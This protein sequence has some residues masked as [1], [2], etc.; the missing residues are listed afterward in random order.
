ME[1]TRSSPSAVV[2]A[3]L[4]ILFAMLVWFIH[5]WTWW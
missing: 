3:I 4:A 1:D 2:W 5:P